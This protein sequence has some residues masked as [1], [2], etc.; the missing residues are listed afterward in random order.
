[1][2]EL[3]EFQK[4]VIANAG[5]AQGLTVGTTAPDLVLTN[6]AGKDISLYDCL[7]NGPVILKFYRGEW[8]PICN[9]DL[10]ELQKHLPE[11]KSLGA[12]LLAVSPQNPNNALTM[13][14]K[15]ILNSKC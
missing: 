3:Q 5:E 4:L 6:A 1:M 13:K 12:A 9:L 7:T 11:I 15:I 2:S 8:C 10:R 14:K